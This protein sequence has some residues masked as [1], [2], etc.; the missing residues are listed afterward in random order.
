[1]DFEVLKLIAEAGTAA[2]ALSIFGWLFLKMFSK[3]FA[4]HKEERGEW[5]AEITV[6]HKERRQESA[7]TRKV[8][9]ELT[10]VIRNIK[11]RS[12]DT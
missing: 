2:V 3:M 9:S 10:D 8:L 7:D 12:N 6:L 5:R 4:S 1:M 11:G